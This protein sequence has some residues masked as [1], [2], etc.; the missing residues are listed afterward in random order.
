MASALVETVSAKVGKQFTVEATLP[1]N[2]FVGLR[3]LPP[4]NYYYEMRI[5]GETI[6][7]RETPTSRTCGLSMAKASRQDETIRE[8]FNTREQLYTRNSRGV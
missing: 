2:R 3:Y 6:T 1:G 8:R 4:F 5:T 7:G